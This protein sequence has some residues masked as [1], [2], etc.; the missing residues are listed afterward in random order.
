MN[1]KVELSWLL[2]QIAALQSDTEY[3]KEGFAH[4]AQM[5]VGGKTAPYEPEDVAGK[6][7]AE[8]LRDIVQGR[9][10]TNQQLLR[11]YEKMYDDCVHGSRRQVEAEFIAKAVSCVPAAEETGTTEK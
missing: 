7:K 5:S 4:L 2:Q 9:E 1:D 3:L 11:L 6:A 10:A 8:A